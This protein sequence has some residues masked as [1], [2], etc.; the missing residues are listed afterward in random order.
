VVSVTPRPRFSPGE[1]TPG[2]H[3]TG[4]CVGPRAGLDKEAIGKIL[5]PCRG[6]NPDRLVTRSYTHKSVDELCNYSLRFLQT[7][8][9]RR[10]RLKDITRQNVFRELPIRYFSRKQRR[11][12]TSCEKPLFPIA[13]GIVVCCLS[14]GRS[15]TSK[16]LSCAVRHQ[17]AR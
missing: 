7:S 11:F 13:V 5:C 6:L 4:G 9:Y 10:K 14:P 8:R 12:G 2:T 3:C 17:D 15:L 16:A 1:R